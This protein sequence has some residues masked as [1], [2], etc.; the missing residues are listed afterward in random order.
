LI[1]SLARD[2]M[3]FEEVDEIAE[4]TGLSIEEVQ[5]ILNEEE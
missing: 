1:I 5:E 3:G 2:L 4:A